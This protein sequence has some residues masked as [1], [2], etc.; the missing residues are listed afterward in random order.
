MFDGVVIGCEPMRSDGSQDMTDPR[1]VIAQSERLAVVETKVEGLKEDTGVIRSNIHVVNNVLQ[2]II[3]MEQRC[4]T[5]LSELIALTKD[6][7]TIARTANSFSEMK[8]EIEAMIDE[9]QQRQGAWRAI[10]RMGAALVG[11][12]SIG[13]C[14]AAWYY[15]HFH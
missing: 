3:S 1:T 7:P 4:E 9:R 5:K 14:A 12:A 15:G 6:L 2:Q 8:D 10:V 13:A 11:A